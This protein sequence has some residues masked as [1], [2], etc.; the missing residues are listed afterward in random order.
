[1]QV[2]SPQVNDDLFLDESADK[3]GRVY[4][5]NLAMAKECEQLA[6]TINRSLRRYKAAQE[7]FFSA[8]IAIVWMPDSP[9]G[10]DAHSEFSIVLQIMEH[11]E[12]GQLA[13]LRKCECGRYFFVRSSIVRFCSEKC[14][15]AY[16]ENSEVRKD[17]KRK[18]AKEYYRLHK[19]KNIK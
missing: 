14:R 16:W 8:G 19:T 7:I 4:L 17:Q 15:I 2:I 1:V 18:K 12:S 3:N 9:V 5:E 11:L 6:D 10:S 13:K